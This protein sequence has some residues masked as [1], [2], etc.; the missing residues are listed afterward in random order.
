MPEI[1]E[2]LL[3]LFRHWIDQDIERAGHTPG[4]FYHWAPS[5]GPGYCSLSRPDPTRPDIER[6]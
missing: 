1:L 3:F 2:S 6:P 5:S 4:Y